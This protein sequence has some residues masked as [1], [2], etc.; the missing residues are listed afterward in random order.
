ME[1]VIPSHLVLG[2]IPENLAGPLATTGNYIFKL[3]STVLHK[4]PFGAKQWHFKL[5]VRCNLLCM[6]LVFHRPEQQR[7]QPGAS[8][9]ICVCG[10]G[11]EFHFLALYCPTCL[12]LSPFNID[13]G[14][15]AC[16]C[17]RWTWPRILHRFP[18]L[19]E[20]QEP[21]SLAERRHKVMQ[22]ERRE[23]GD[24]RSG[25]ST[26]KPELEVAQWDPLN[27]FC[28]ALV[29]WNQGRLMAL[30]LETLH[31]VFWILSQMVAV[32]LAQAVQFL[33]LTFL[34]R[35]GFG[36]RNAENMNARMMARTRPPVLSGVGQQH[37][38]G[39]SRIQ[40]PWPNHN[41]DPA[42]WPAVRT[43]TTSRTS[44]GG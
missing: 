10:F 39:H 29:T 27:P 6:A 26:V 31:G 40:D 11:F 41:G 19:C 20:A 5:G 25:H 38:H 3:V 8:Q 44:S 43:L 14:T 13:F 17:L 36:L 15:F 7:R 22:S 2:Q 16:L 9:G 21:T 33:V 30:V 24:G 37:A 28:V 23:M 1:S 34:S 32:A 35:P 12:I 42:G 4:A 18:R